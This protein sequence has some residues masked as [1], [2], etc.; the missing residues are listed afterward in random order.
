VVGRDVI[1]IEPRKSQLIA[2]AFLDR[3]GN[4]LALG[5]RAAGASAMS[6]KM[7]AFIAIL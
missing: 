4:G 7:S 6:L 3:G 5:D 1:G 2:G